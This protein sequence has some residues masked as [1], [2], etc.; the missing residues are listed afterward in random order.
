MT[1]V[2][3]MNGTMINVQNGIP[4]LILEAVAVLMNLENQAITENNRVE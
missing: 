1:N 2:C 3:I 4:Q